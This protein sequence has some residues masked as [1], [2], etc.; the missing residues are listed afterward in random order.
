[1]ERL[2]L[3]VEQSPRWPSSLVTLAQYKQVSSIE[4]HGAISEKL[5]IN[6]DSCSYAL[7][8]HQMMTLSTCSS[9]GAAK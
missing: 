4:G 6:I 1:L 5:S 8:P 2:V 3:M 9:N 7:T